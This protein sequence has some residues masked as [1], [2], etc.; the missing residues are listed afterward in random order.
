MCLGKL[1]VE[2]NSLVRVV[3]GALVGLVGGYPA[4]NERTQQIA[5]VGES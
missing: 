1:I 2:F 5:N 4:V 3:T